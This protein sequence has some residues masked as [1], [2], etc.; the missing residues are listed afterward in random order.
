MWNRFYKGIGK[1]MEPFDHGDVVTSWRVCHSQYCC[2]LIENRL[3]KCPQLG[4]L[5]IV[6]EKFGLHKKIPAWAENTSEYKGIGLEST[7]DELQQWLHERAGPEAV[8]E[9]CPANLDNYEKDIY[10]VNFDLPDVDR[11]ERPIVGGGARS[12]RG[13]R[14]AVDA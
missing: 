4:N 1:N 6:S 10:N 3:W 5:H 14:E 7:D 12:M 13:I 2:N 11:F 8:C 9:M